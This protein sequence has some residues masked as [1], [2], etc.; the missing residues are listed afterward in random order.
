MLPVE[1]ASL[2]YPG[3]LVCRTD[4]LCGRV[5]AA[6]PDTALVDWGRLHELIPTSELE[7]ADVYAARQLLKGLGQEPAS[8]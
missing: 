7:L 8:D 6:N 1:M 5:V 4:G 2:F 3:D